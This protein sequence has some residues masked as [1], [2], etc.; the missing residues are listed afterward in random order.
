MRLIFG[1]LFVIPI[2]LFSQSKD[3]MHNS[4][5]Y[6]ALGDSYTIGE[7]VQLHQ[8]FPYQVVQILRKKGFNFQAPEIIARTGWTTDELLEGMKAYEF[9]SKYDFVTLLIGVNNQYRGREVIEYKEQFEEILKKAIELAHGKKDHVFVISI[10][11][12]GSTPFAADADT[13]K[14]SRETD[15]FNTV[16]KALSIQYKAQYID[17]TTL[18]R[19]AKQY[20]ALIAEDKLHPSSIAYSKWAEK[21]ADAITLQLK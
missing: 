2:Q 7:A 15:V 10:P 18:S 20:P 12:W 19:E 13:E 11:D 5:S 6:L 21:I 17:I 3:T 14:I 9:L 4:Y 8:D 1:L 16:N